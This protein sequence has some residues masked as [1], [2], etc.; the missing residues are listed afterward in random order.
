MKLPSPAQSKTSAGSDFPRPEPGNHLARLVA[1]VDLGT[2]QRSYQGKDYQSREVYLVWELVNQ[3]MPDG[4]SN[5]LV[6]RSYA[7]SMHEKSNLRKMLAKWRGSDF[8]DDEAFELSLI[9]G[10]PCLLDV[11]LVKDKYV[12]LDPL[13]VSR[14]PQGM[15]CPTPR[16][17]P[18]LWE[19]ER[20][21]S[22]PA[23]L[24]A[25]P[26]IYGTPVPERIKQS[27]EWQAK[28]QKPAPGPAD[29]DDYE[30]SAV[31]EIP[32]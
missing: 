16:M 27:Q 5:H 29:S 11:Q 32:F 23:A 2:V 10:K 19:L 26:Y 18:Y 30:E 25:L 9:L 20:S 12:K 17:K 7:T 14:L 6:G 24:A 21:D 8:R 4:K 22:L 15:T 31:D 28:G 1:I 13:C 3:A